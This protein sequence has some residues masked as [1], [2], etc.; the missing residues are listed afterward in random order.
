MTTAS[1]VGTAPGGLPFLGHLLPLMRDPLRF[2]TSLPAHGDLVYIR[3]GPLKALAVCDPG[4]TRQVLVDDRT[5]DK[6][7]PQIEQAREALGNGLPLCPHAEHRRQRRL[8]QPAFRAARLPTYARVMTQETAAVTG[9]W[10]DGQTFDVYVEMQRIAAQSFVA[11][12][13]ADTL[14]ATALTEMLE[15]FGV[16]AEGI[17]RRMITPPLLNGLPTPG[18]RRYHR[19]RS[20]LRGTMARVIADRRSD[21]TGDD[22][23][24]LSV[25]LNTPGSTEGDKDQGLSDAEIIDQLMDFFF[26]GIET[27]A[28]VLAWTLHLLTNH[29][30]I[31]ERLHAEV[32]D[33][34]AGAAATFDD[35]PRLE[36]TR[37]VIDETL[38]LYPPGWLISRTTTADTRLGG[39]FLRAGTAIIYSPYLIHHRAD[40]YD[41]PERFDPDR[42]SGPQRLSPS[43]G[44]FIP[45]GGGARKC[46]G[47]QFALTEAVIIL[48]TIAARWRLEPL[49]GSRVR[50]SMALTLSPQRLTMRVRPRA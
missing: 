26:A 14:T 47:D 38:R 24:L 41:D 25:F 10:S 4:L 37:R 18:N 44:S 48:A 30:G 32:D 28:A 29:P 3:I 36:Y 39:H 11:T 1:S 12:V 15:D 9:S 34:L 17:F 23:D 27:T 42:W 19:A 45:F 13:F 46:I 49:P 31:E 8:V 21:G 5:F 20:R 16:I 50:P 40:Q 35:V 7:G 2:L 33:V 43:D 22:D 6:G